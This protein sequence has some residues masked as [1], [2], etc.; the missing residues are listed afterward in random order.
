M[1]V[2]I[3]ILALA[4]VTAYAAPVE[5]D[6]DVKALLKNLMALQQPTDEQT[7]GIES[8]INEQKNQE[9]ERM[10]SLLAQLQADED[11][12]ANIEEYFAQD[13]APA[14]EQFWKW[15]IPFIK[16]ILFKKFKHWGR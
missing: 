10:L 2:A 1:K 3:L 16:K 13:Q 12:E 7:P 14:E 5:E 6:A 8:L 4:T 11:R 15:K 9:E